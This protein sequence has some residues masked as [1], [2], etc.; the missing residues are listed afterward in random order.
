MVELAEA[1]PQWSGVDNPDGLT[2][3]MLFKSNTCLYVTAVS[4]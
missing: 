3:G 2:T 1:V 4:S